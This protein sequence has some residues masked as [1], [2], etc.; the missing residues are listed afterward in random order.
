MGLVV[1]TL[2]ISLEI[3]DKEFGNGMS[4]FVNLKGRYEDGGV[5]IEE[6]DSVIVDSLDLFCS[7][8]KS[9]L[10]SKFAQGVLSGNEYKTKLDE[11]IRRTKRVKE[12]LKKHDGDSIPPP[13]TEQ[14][15]SM[16]TT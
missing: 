11:I 10:G 8:W 14:P 12:Y 4:R 16:V 7:A 15:N 2:T 5:S 6:L 3:A 13:S 1:N 9:L